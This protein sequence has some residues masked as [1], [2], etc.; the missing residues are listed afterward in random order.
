[1]FKNI[2]LVSIRNF[3]R[4][5]IHTLVNLS[6]LSL[7]ISTVLV[8]FLML[9][10]LFSYDRYH[11]NYDHIYRL[12]SEEDNHSGHG[13]D[14]MVGVPIVLPEAFADEFPEV[15]E[16][17]F[18]SNKTGGIISVK[19]KEDVEEN[20]GIVY[21]EPSFFKIF[22]R[23]LLQGNPEKVLLN[24]GKVVISEKWAKK[25]FGEADPIGKTFTMDFETELMVEGVMEDFP[26]NTDFP[27]DMFIAYNTVK[28]DREKKEGWGST[29]SDDQ[30]YILLNDKDSKAKIE[31]RLPAF[32]KKY[33][34]DRDTNSKAMN[35]QPMS[36][37]HFSELYSTISF[38]TV[39]KSMLTL[40]AIIGL[41]ILITSCVNFINLSTALAVKRAREIG[42]RKVMGSSR[43]FL[44]AQLL[45]ETAF[46]VVIAM[47]VS[48]GITEVALYYL[49]P[50]LELQL[51]ILKADTF[52]LITFLVLL[53]IFLTIMAGLYP[54][55]LISSFHPINS[56]KSNLS[57]RM[58]G[59]RT[60]RQGL[61]VFQFIISQVFIICTIVATQQTDFLK[62]VDMGFAREANISVQL[63]EEN[64]VR[65]KSFKQEVAQLNDVENITLAYKPP[66]SGS[67]SA[68][69][70]KFPANPGDYTT[71]VK[72]ADRDY[73]PT[74]QL[75]L[76]AGENISESDTIKDFVINESLM[77]QLGVNESEKIVGEKL[78]VW[79][80]TGIIKGVVANFQ[81]HSM[82]ARF[83]PV[84]ITS[85]APNY[86]TAGVKLNTANVHRTVEQIESIY[87]KHYGNYNFEY[88]F[89]DE[90]IA[91]FYEAEEKMTTLTKG[92]SFIAI[93]IGMLGLYGLVAYLTEIKTKEIG[94]RKALG[95]TIYDVLI[96]LTRGYSSL[97]ALAFLFALPLS[98]FMLDTWLA[99][100]PHRIEL[101]FL[102]F[103]AGGLLS[104]VVA[105]LTAAYTSI[106]AARLNPTVSLRDN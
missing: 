95:A 36:D 20:S 3:V 22:D 84:L 103:L 66:S 52:S 53:L 82:K 2:F 67:T 34:G 78:T 1:M 56:L 37:F 87:K 6:G 29:S 64:T 98:W 5:K 7:G 39:P 106:K 89:L 93:F 30:L 63:K 104:L 12:V 26:E 32:I 9:S 46:M 45:G 38:N 8:I 55:R 13:K 44:V 65:A 18:I 68:T 23:K 94:V 57:N 16:Q 80:R 96:L 14:Y 48:F 27:I 73:L 50:F 88:S 79:G 42:I 81:T 15:K 100:Y 40:M 25:Y 69:N 31:G 17:V 72:L 91:E 75:K 76:L 54:A 60:L 86:K 28:E 35:L 33:F 85:Y 24:P 99:E 102:S 59:G 61:V 58:T 105:L 51:G 74:Y 41:F 83:E 97:I 71:E 70:V 43:F 21:S 62:T 10:F 19:G 49:N 101:N 11:E 90:D 92:F 47:L 77:K 4:Q